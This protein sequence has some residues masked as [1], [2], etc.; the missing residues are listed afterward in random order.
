MLQVIERVAR[1][2]N[3]IVMLNMQHFTQLG[4]SAFG[5]GLLRLG[6]IDALTYAVKPRALAI[7]SGRKTEEVG[8]AIVI[9]QAIPSEL[10]DAR[11][12]VTSVT[13]IP[14]AQIIAVAA[15]KVR[16]SFAHVLGALTVL[17]EV[18]GVEVI[19]EVRTLPPLLHLLPQELNIFHFQLPHPGAGIGQL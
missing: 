18:H 8:I 7:V 12:E 10:M 19:V 17:D 13:N 2:I 6:T 5:E 3:V 16:H 1:L 15:I 4:N 11:L 14:V 9:A